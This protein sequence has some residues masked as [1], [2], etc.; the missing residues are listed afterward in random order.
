MKGISGSLVDKAMERITMQTTEDFTEDHGKIVT[1]MVKMHRSIIKMVTSI[2][3]QWW[4]MTD[5]IAKDITSGT[6]QEII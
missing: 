5:K 1:S 4:T 3:D 6:A 2:V